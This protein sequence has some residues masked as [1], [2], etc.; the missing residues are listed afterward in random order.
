MPIPDYID[1]STYTLEII[2][3]QLIEDENQHILDIANEFF[4]I[5]AWQRLEKSMIFGQPNFSFLITLRA[6][7]RFSPAAFR[8]LPSLARG[9]TIR[10]DMFAIGTDAS[11]EGVGV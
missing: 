10:K 5:E 9:G 4:R 11:K 2:L 3:K 1:N 7:I 8:A 6:K